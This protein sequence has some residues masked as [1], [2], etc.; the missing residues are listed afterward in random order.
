MDRRARSVYLQN[1]AA[2]RLGAMKQGLTAP[3]RTGVEV[4]LNLEGVEGMESFLCALGE[5]ING[6]NGYFG[7]DLSSLQDCLIGGFGLTAPWT[8]RVRGGPPSRVLGAAALLEL[9]EFE[10]ALRGEGDVG[11]EWSREVRRAALE[12]RSDLWRELCAV[13]E[14]FGVRVREDVPTLEQ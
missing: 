5:A 1:A 12:G 8:L 3:D 7:R 9:V 11:V 13:F 4:V 6:P 2:Q 10:M 14:H